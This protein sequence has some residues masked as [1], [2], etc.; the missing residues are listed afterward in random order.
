M[1]K[2]RKTFGD[3]ELARKMAER[4]GGDNKTI[5]VELRHTEEVTAFVRKVEEAR[6]QAATSDLVFKGIGERI[7][8]QC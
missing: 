4:F 7:G 2:D 8:L 6:Q 5:S 1:E 3:A